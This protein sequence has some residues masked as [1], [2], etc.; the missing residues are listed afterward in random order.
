MQQC[1]WCDVSQ[2]VQEFYKGKKMCKTCYKGRY[3]GKRKIENDQDSPRV[4]PR[5]AVAKP[6]PKPKALKRKLK[7]PARH[8]RLDH[9]PR[10][11]QADGPV[12]AVSEV[13]E[14]AMVV[15]EIPV[16]QA[17]VPEVPEVPEVV[18]EAPVVPEEVAMVVT[19]IPVVVEAPA[20]PVAVIEAAPVAVIEAAPVAVIE[21]PKVVSLPPAPPPLPPLPILFPRVAAMPALPSTQEVTQAPPQAPPSVAPKPPLYRPPASARATGYQ[22]TIFPLPRTHVIKPTPVRAKPVAVPVPAAPAAT[23]APAAPKPVAPAPL[24]PPEPCVPRRDP[25]PQR[26]V[27]RKQQQQVFQEVQ[28]CRNRTSAPSRSQQ[29][30]AESRIQSLEEELRAMRANEKQ[31]LAEKLAV[32]N[33]N[34][35]L[36]T[37]VQ[38]A[39]NQWRTCRAENQVNI[40]GF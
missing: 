6:K 9:R 31:I 8:P 14:V 3:N 18:I 25:A 32:E 20:A 22:P 37:K 5:T 34:V 19:E 11:A 27:L 7:L 1:T 39:I 36:K 35:A 10:Q 29:Q 28:M 26:E 2:N 30:I 4:R 38:T 16:V 15:A 21:A 13:P 33:E 17:D 12:A 24:I 40:L 23:P